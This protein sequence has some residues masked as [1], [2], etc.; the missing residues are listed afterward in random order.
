[1]SGHGG[2]DDEDDCAGDGDGDDSDDVVGDGQVRIRLNI[3]MAIEY[4]NKDEYEKAK[5][6]NEEETI[7]DPAAEEEQDLE[8]IANL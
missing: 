6:G 2:D 8:D 7:E 4:E 3:L 1:M 5:K